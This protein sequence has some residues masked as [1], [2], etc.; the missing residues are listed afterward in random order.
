[1]IQLGCL[2]TVVAHGSE[3]HILHIAGVAISFKGV[4]GRRPKRRS[5]SIKKH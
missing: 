3:L 4:L 2:L 1:M 5:F